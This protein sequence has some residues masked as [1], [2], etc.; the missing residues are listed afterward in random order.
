MSGD[1]DEALS[2]D[3][4]WYL[5][6][7]LEKAGK[8][9]PRNLFA[10]AAR[11]ERRRFKEDFVEISLEK[12]DLEPFRMGTGRLNR[13]AIARS[14]QQQLIERNE[15]LQAGKAGRKA[16]RIGIRTIELIVNRWEKVKIRDN[17][18]S[19]LKQSD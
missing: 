11:T 16:S 8:P 13:R 19:G 2:L 6:F 9:V 18:C 3:E 7:E 15:A 17:P 10:N 1:E 12:M 14:I 5:A 4:A